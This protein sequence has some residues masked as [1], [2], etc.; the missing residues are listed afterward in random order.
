MVMRA[1]RM[2]NINKYRYH[3]VSEHEESMNQWEIKQME[4]TL[5]P[6][7]LSLQLRP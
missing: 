1:M 5:K 6:V 4:T 2:M 7:Y 3:K